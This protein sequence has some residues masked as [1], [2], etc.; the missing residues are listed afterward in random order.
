LFDQ[1]DPEN[2]GAARTWAIIA[3]SARPEI[4][5]YMQRHGYPRIQHARKGAGSVEE[6]ITFLQNYTIVVH[7]RCKHTID[8][9]TLY[10][11]TTDKLTG[12]VLPI[13]EKKKN[14]V[15]DALRYAVESLRAVKP[16]A[17]AVLADKWR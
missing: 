5:S 7:P 2:P 3:D 17:A 12:Q 14:H 9:L 4:I 6:G 11:Y 10:S 16:T 8:E 15:I 13:L 1:L